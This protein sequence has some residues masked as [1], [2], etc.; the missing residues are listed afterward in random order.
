MPRDHQYTPTP[1]SF[2]QNIGR[3]YSFKYLFACEPRE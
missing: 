1:L 3:A 2:L